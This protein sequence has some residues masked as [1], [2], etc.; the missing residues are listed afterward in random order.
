[1]VGKPAR[2]KTLGRPRLRWNVILKWI[3]KNW[4]GGGHGLNW[5]GLG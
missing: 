5:S 2:K 4:K 1:L 3:F